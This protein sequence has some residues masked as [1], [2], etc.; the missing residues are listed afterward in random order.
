MIA[1]LWSS[2]LRLHEAAGRYSSKRTPG[3]FD[4]GH[5]SQITHRQPGGP[6]RVILAPE[7]D[8]G[9]ARSSLSPDEKGRKG[10]RRALGRGEPVPYQGTR[11]TMLSSSPSGFAK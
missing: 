5:G 8:D 10:R 3:D 11:P 6:W 7:F 2:R 1:S 9:W 4:A